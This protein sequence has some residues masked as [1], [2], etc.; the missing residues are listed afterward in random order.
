MNKRPFRAPYLVQWNKL[1]ST[2]A[3]TPLVDKVV[4][5]VLHHQGIPFKHTSE[6]RSLYS[7]DKLWEQLE[8]YNPKQ[9]SNVLDGHLRDGLKFA[10]SQF[11]RPLSQEKLKPVK[12]VTEAADLMKTLG[13]R[14]TSA[15]LTAYGESKIEAFAV[16]LDK[17]VDILVNDKAPSPALAGVRTQRNGKTR[18]VWNVPLEM[19][20]IEATV[21]RQIIDD[22]KSRDMVMTFGDTS[23]EIGARMRRCASEY[24]YHMSIDYSQFDSS[25]RAD[26][27]KHAFNAMR[28]WYD[29]DDEVYQGVKLSRVFDLVE[30][31]FACTPLVMPMRGSKYPVLVTGKVSGVPSGSYFTSVIDSFCNVALIAAASSRFDLGIGANNLFVLGDDCLFFTNASITLERIQQFLATY[32]FKTNTSKGSVGSSTDLIEYLGRTWRNG[33]PMRSFS[34]VLR[35]SLYPEKFR[36]YPEQV[37]AK[38]R[39]ALSLLNSYRL[40]SYVEDAP[41]EYAN[42]RHVNII[43]SRI[44]SGFARYLLAEGLVPGKTLTRAIF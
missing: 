10:F 38:E 23:H 3:T 27:I 37:G 39:D 2:D 44:S 8:H 17:A 30:R 12:L 1:M 26:I 25:V 5:A 24:K 20:I 32:G 16:G 18:L 11:A 9:R 15:G 14:E 6:Y 22:F 29:L 7:Y 40:T 36:K 43:P 13:I 31:Y 35:G 41:E 33:F 19:I 34:D 4:E 21:A 42:V 28:T